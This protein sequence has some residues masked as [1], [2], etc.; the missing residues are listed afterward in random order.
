MAAAA[1][2]VQ[3]VLGF[4]YLAALPSDLV[5]TIM[6]FNSSIG[7]HFLSSLVV[8]MPFT[9]CVIALTVVPCHRGLRWTTS[10]LGALLVFAMVTFSQKLREA[11]LAEHFTLEEWKVETQVGPILI[12][13]VL[14]I[15]GLACVGWITW[16]TWR[17]FADSNGRSRID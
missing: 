5:K 4:W 3:M 2:M 11:L 1:T 12:F 15:L 7:W 8:V 9:V 10:G 6:K 13:L 17:G 14:F 16:V